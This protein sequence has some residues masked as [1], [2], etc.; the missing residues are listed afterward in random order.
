MRKE[1]VSRALTLVFSGIM[2]FCAVGFYIRGKH[3]YIYN[4][5]PLLIGYLF[6]LYLENRLKFRVQNYIKALVLLT[7][8][9]HVLIG[10]YFRL[11]YTSNRFDK[12]LH[13][14]GIFSVSLFA[15]RIIYAFV[16]R[17]PRSKF[18]TFLII[19]SLGIS[20]GTLFEIFEFALDVIFDTTNQ[21]GLRDTNLDMIF[22][23]IG[24]VLAGIWG[25]LSTVKINREGST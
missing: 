1:S 6:F 7:A 9:G 20:I 4:I 23:S 16:R 13:M 10:Q 14:F 2:I 22:N 17:A 18:Y 5:V 24:A 15:Y 21:P 19:T 25:S 11:Y 12:G 3:N 8:V